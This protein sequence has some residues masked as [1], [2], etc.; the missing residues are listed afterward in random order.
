VLDSLVITESRFAVEP[1][2]IAQIAKM[3]LRIYEVGVSYFG[4]TYA[5]GKK[6]TWKDGVAAIFAI[7]RYNIRHGK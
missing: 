6:I 5:D 7:L 4:R 3:D 1:Q 2:I